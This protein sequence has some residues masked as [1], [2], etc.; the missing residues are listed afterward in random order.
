MLDPPSPTEDVVDA[1]GDFIPHV[2]ISVP[3]KNTALNKSNGHRHI[4]VPIRE[5][6][7]W[8][9]TSFPLTPP[10]FLKTSV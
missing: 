3:A 4:T 9:K 1:R 5:N 2:V 6:V 8:V 7:L 10:H